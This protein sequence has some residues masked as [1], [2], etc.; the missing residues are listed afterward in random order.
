VVRY[1]DPQYP[2]PYPPLPPNLASLFAVLDVQGYEGLVNRRIEE[3]AALVDPAMPR[4]RHLIGEI[5]RR[6]ALDSPLLDLMRVRY[7]LATGVFPLADARSQSGAGG[8]EII[9]EDVVARAAEPESL[10]PAT[11]VQTRPSALEFAELPSRLILVD[12][13]EDALEF[14]G[15]PDFDPRREAVMLREDAGTLGLESSADVVDFAAEPGSAEVTCEHHGSATLRLRYRSAQPALL[16]LAETWHPG[17]E[18]E[19]AGGIPL[20]VTRADHA[21]R[22]LLLPAGEGEVILRFRPR[23]FAYGIAA[24]ILGLSILIGGGVISC[25]RRQP[26]EARDS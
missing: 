13:D 12:S 19:I 5:T 7:V 3:L 17:W 4:A 1:R 11:L 6:A 25:R 26:P 18:A 20:P 9:V 21:F 22:A 10:V 14:L 23:S 24:A 2:G 16:L 15:R 8:I